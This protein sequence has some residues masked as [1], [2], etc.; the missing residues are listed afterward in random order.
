MP[1]DALPPQ[2]TPDDAV[3]DN[4]AP[5]SV[6]ATDA[7]AYAE[8]PVDIAS[9]APR[10]AMGAPL[11]GFS[12]VLVQ[13]LKESLRPKRL[14]ATALILLGLAAA[15]AYGARAEAGR[16]R[17]GDLLFQIWEAIDTHVLMILLPLIAL[18]FV[19][20]I[21]SRET[22]QRTMVYL[23]VRPVSRTTV[24]LSRFAAGVIPAA[25][26]SS[27]L[28]IGIVLFASADTPPQLLTALPLTC[29]F[30]TL[31]LGA[32]YCTLG[33]IFKRGLVAGLLYTFMVEVVVAG[34][35]GNIQKFSV[36]FH[37]R[38][39]YHGL[40]DGP[41]GE[42]SQDIQTK[43]DGVGSNDLNPFVETLAWDPPGTAIVVL[44]AVTAAVLAF[45]VMKVRGRDF[46]LKD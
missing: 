3:P 31:V 19:G 39:L 36:R 18:I 1:D 12:I 16:P 33:A 42:R 41:L 20:P 32:I 35:P 11:A 46:A 23:L 43:V 4:A 25:L 27:V 34:L 21:Y 26:W 24:F 6:Q 7:S 28:C 8:R 29:F 44:L 17:R 5:E 40:V 22:R 15:V 9:H 2:P 30:G 37:L 13:G 10:R 45:G 38:G 14:V